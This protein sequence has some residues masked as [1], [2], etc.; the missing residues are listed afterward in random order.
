MEFNFK[1]KYIKLFISILI[2]NLFL[3]SS[4]SIYEYFTRI[5]VFSQLKTCKT[6]LPIGAYKENF[7]DSASISTFKKSTKGFEFSFTKSTKLTH[8]FAALYIPIEG[9]NI[10]FTKYNKLKIIILSN[11]AKRIPVLL[12]LKYANNLERYLTSFIDIKK[13]VNEYEL[14]INQFQTP[15]EWF[16]HN[17]LSFNELPK[18]QFQNIQTISIESCHLLPKG[19]ND[20]YKIE[21]I[22]FYK[23]I[24]FETY[25]FIIIDIIGSIAIILYLIKPFK[26]KEKIIHLPIVPIKIGENAKNIDKISEFIAHNYTNPD[27]T[28]QIIQKELGLNA[29]EISKEIKKNFDLSFPQ[30]LNKVRIEEAKRI[31][32]QEKIDSIA[33]VAYKVGFNSPNNFNRVFKNMEE[34]TPKEFL[35]N[36]VK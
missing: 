34:I 18:S 7:S 4:L 22:I 25:L 24:D 11:K 16:E 32:T 29:Q 1:N 17:K 36:S 20:T 2:L 15:A 5:N 6:C 23:N 8:T 10:E 13:D 26:T 33:D 3:Y 31:F 35:Q 9:L 30:Y 12:S 14:M 19:E 21:K 27:L 28:L